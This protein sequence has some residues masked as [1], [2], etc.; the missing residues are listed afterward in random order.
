MITTTTCIVLDRLGGDVLSGRIRV[1]FNDANIHVVRWF[2]FPRIRLIR[3][4]THRWRY[5][6]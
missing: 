5:V 1:R 2:N 3:A 4:D 6:N